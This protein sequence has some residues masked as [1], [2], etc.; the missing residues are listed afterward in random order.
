MIVALVILLVCEIVLLSVWKGL[1]EDVSGLIETWYLKG[2]KDLMDHIND[3]SVLYTE[4]E[5]IW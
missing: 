5:L 2:D 3:T 1:S 4:E